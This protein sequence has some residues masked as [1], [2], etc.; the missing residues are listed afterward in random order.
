MKGIVINCPSKESREE[1]L[2]NF[3]RTIKKSKSYEKAFILSDDGDCME[4]IEVTDEVN[5]A[6]SVVMIMI[7]DTVKIKVSGVGMCRLDPIELP[8][9]AFVVVNARM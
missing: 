8:E 7:K 1:F 3:F 9:G 5:G 2:K 4:C 6:L